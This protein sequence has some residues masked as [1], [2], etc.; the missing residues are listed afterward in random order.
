[1]ILL[2]VLNK[3]IAYELLPMYFRPRPPN[4]FSGCATA[5]MFVS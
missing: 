1:M 3:E 2:D 4:V 5:Y